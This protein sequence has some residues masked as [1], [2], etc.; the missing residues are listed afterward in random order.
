[1][2]KHT[3]GSIG[4]LTMLSQEFLSPLF[5]KSKCHTVCYFHIKKRRLSQIV[6]KFPEASDVFNGDES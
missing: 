1:M 5:V 3:S 6:I 4:P 2:P